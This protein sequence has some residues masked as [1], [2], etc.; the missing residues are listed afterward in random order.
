[1][2]MMSCISVLDDVM[3][4][5]ILI[6]GI[7][8]GLTW[9]RKIREQGGECFNPAKGSLHTYSKGFYYLVRKIVFLLLE[10][11]VGF[12]SEDDGIQLIP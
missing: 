10:C 3:D 11:A 6:P 4:S 12:L 1:M 2:A 9:R 7:W 8:W 5:G